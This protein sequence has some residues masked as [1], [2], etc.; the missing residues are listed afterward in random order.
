[1]PCDGRIARI[2]K[3]RAESQVRNSARNCPKQYGDILVRALRG[4]RRDGEATY[5]LPGA[6]PRADNRCLLYRPGGARHGRFG[7]YCQQILALPLMMMP[8]NDRLVVQE[9]RG[10]GCVELCKRSKIRETLS[11]RPCFGW[12]QVL[13]SG[14]PHMVEFLSNLYIPQGGVE[15]A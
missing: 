1:M 4:G 8:L 14:L 12:A 15:E 3:L 5:Y 6:L 2:L 11:G 13:C 7:G 9:L 10:L